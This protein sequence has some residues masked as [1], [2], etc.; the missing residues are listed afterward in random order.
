M[1]LHSRIPSRSPNRMAPTRSCRSLTFPS[2]SASNRTR[3][4]THPATAPSSGSI[5][6]WL[7]SLDPQ[8]R[9][10]SDAR[11]E[12]RARAVRLT[13]LAAESPEPAACRPATLGQGML[14]LRRAAETTLPAT[15]ANSCARSRSPLP[16]YAQAQS[17]AA[18]RPSRPW[19]AV[20]RLLALRPR[21]PDRQLTRTR[22]LTPPRPKNLLRISV[23]S[24][25]SQ[26][27]VAPPRVTVLG[28]L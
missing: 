7:S 8:G 6:S 26:P 22:R 3:L 18:R 12:C 1:T 13:P 11:I 14:R 27:F 20:G 5:L 25:G 24:F 15:P 2:T 17:P 28:V 10:G 16:A 23:G 4:R 9:R 21:R 19:E